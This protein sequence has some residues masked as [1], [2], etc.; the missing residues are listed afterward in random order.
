MRLESG[1]GALEQSSASGKRVN[2]L[3][4]PRRKRSCQLDALAEATEVKK[5]RKL[6]HSSDMHPVTT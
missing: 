6:R 3:A 5:K 2:N 4:S 1:R